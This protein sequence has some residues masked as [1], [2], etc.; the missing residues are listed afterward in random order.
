MKILVDHGAYANLG[1]VAMLESAVTHLSAAVPDA[2]LCVVYR[3]FDSPIWRHPRVSKQADIKVHLG[4]D[5]VLAKLFGRKVLSVRN[6]LLMSLLGV[7]VPA[8]SLL[9]SSGPLTEQVKDF[10]KRFDGMLI[11]GG[12]FLNDKFSASLVLKC[13]LAL[14]FAEQNKPV[15]LTGQQIGPF[16]LRSSRQLVARALQ[17]AQFVGLRD[18]SDSVTY[19]KEAGLLPH[20]YAVMGDDSL[21]LTPASDVDVDVD[22]LILSS[23]LQQTRDF[24]AINMRVSKMYAKEH[25]RHVQ[26]F[27][28]LIKHLIERTGRPALVVPIALGSEDS[29]IETGRKLAS[30]LPDQ[31]LYVLASDNLTPAGVKGVLGRAWGAVGIA[32]HFCTFALSMGV[33]TVCLYDGSYYQQKASTIT[34]FWNDG[35]LALPLK[36]LDLDMASEHIIKTFEDKHLRETLPERAEAAI[37]SWRM[38]FEERVRTAFVK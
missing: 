6:R 31:P 15:V 27:A 36:N 17:K 38:T 37:A 8:A 25:E 33:P 22:E 24:L 4:L 5:D 13:T 2:E 35:R 16:T 23:G 11:V 34:S 7:R 9:I 21:G 14:A 28:A 29:D 3:Q 10:C 32:Y 12:G 26:R 30:L 19:C 18:P 1:D 20:R